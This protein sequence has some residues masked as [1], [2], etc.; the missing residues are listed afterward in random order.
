MFKHI[1]AGDS[2]GGNLAMAVALKISR[3]HEEPSH[4]TS[5]MLIY[6]CLQAFDFKLSS[7]KEFDFFRK[8]YSALTRGAM[9]FFHTMYAFGNYD[10][11]KMFADNKHI[12]S[13]MKKKYRNRVNPQILQGK[14][15][16][17]PNDDEDTGNNQISPSSKTERLL[18]FLKKDPNIVPHLK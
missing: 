15:K 8:P 1:F 18:I 5:L 9:I 2:C 16:V 13:E 11:L 7:Y 6:P 17:N 14:Y 4:L 3:S 10:N 12:S